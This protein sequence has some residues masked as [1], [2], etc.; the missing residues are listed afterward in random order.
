MT[1]ISLDP[2]DLAAL[3]ASRV[4]HDVISP[5]GAIVNGLEILEDEKDAEM[6]A[7]ALNL[8]RASAQNASARLQFCRLAFGA[9]GSA[10]ASID[11]G[12]AEKVARGLFSDP[13]IRL[14]W[15]AAR[16]LMPKNKVKL[17]LNLC[18]IGA[19]SIPRG[20]EVVVET[21]ERRADG[22]EATTP[23]LELHV[24]A[25]GPNA[26]LPARTLAILAGHEG[27]PIDAHAIQPYYALL[28]ARVAGMALRIDADAKTVAIVAV[29]SDVEEARSAA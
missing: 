27:E 9:V 3:L 22:A 25:S 26:K 23:A 1:Q 11:T 18:L 16:V 28:V 24:R 21:F 8:I 2:L 19:A 4:C 12:D 6:R 20:G 7:E 10:G 5:V 13:K 15:R 17:I 29:P 14:D